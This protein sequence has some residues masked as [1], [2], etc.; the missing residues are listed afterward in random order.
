MQRIIK[1]HP[2]LADTSV[3]YIVACDITKFEFGI[4]VLKV[5]RMTEQIL[6]LYYERIHIVTNIRTILCFQNITIFCF[7]V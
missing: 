1:V 4:W 5:K 7:N 2:L 6:K 3:I